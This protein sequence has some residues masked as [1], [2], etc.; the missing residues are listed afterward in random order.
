MSHNNRVQMLD[1]FDAL[2]RS[3]RLTTQWINNL[4]AGLSEALFAPSGGRNKTRLPHPDGGFTILDYAFKPGE[5]AGSKTGRKEW[6]EQKSDLIT[7]PDGSNEVFRPA[8][9]GAKRYVMDAARHGRLARG[10][11]DRW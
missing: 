9:G 2:G 1:E 6:V 4:R 8:V 3:A 7:A 11:G 10:P 5:R